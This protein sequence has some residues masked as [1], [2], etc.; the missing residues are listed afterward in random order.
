MCTVAR[1]ISENLPKRA[2]QTRAQEEAQAQKLEVKK[3]EAAAAAA[4]AEPVP[5]MSENTGDITPGHMIQGAGLSQV[6]TA[7]HTTVIGSGASIKQTT[8]M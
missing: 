2:N 5:P 1:T 3:H 6:I 7:R 4:A 8:G